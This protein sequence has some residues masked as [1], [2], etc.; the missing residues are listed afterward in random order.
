MT[1]LP[2]LLT[3]ALAAISADTEAQMG[4]LITDFT[5]LPLNEE[6]R[7]SALAGTVATIAVT[8][9]AR[10]RDIFVAALRS[11]ALEISITLAPPAPRM[12]I[13]SQPGPIG[14]AQDV[15]LAGIDTILR[16]MVAAGTA[17]HHRLVT[18]L[19]VMAQLL[20]R[21]DSHS[22]YLVLNAASSAYADP[23][24]SGGDAVPI[25][26]GDGWLPVMRDADIETVAPRGTA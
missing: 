19:A 5:A 16:R 2:P 7:L 15:L 1:N 20:G 24:W 13:D 14:E 26:L 25:S 8:R 17:K 3:E 4:D 18:E 12:T 21:Y 23:I 10:H 6:D 11:W 9:Y 22:I